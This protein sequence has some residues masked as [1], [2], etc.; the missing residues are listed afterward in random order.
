MPDGW[1][2]PTTRISSLIVEFKTPAEG[3]ETE[4]RFVRSGKSVRPSVRRAWEYSETGFA[5]PSLLF[6]FLLV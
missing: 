5:V 6:F 1:F 2:V 4:T 3:M